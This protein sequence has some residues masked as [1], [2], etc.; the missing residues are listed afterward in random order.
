[1]S[2]FDIIGARK[3]G[4]SDAEIADHLAKSRGFD[5]A[6]ARKAGYSDAEILSH[7][8]GLAPAAQPPAEAPPVAP[9][10]PV[11]AAMSV[12]NPPRIEDAPQVG[13]GPRTSQTVTPAKPWGEVGREAWDNAPASLGNVLKATVQPILH[14]IDTANA[15][16]SVVR[17]LE[18]PRQMV[19][20]TLPNGQTVFQPQ[21]VQETA[22]ETEARTAPA[23]A[24]GDFYANRYGSVEGFKNAFA[25]DPASVFADMSVPLTAGGSVA[26]RAPGVVGKVG[27]IATTAGRVIDPVS[28]SINLTGQV[29]G[30]VGKAGEAVASNT[31][32]I[33]TGA[34]TESIR[35]AGRAGRE[36]GEAGKAFTEN[37]RG[38]VPIEN[39]VNLAKSGLDKIRKERG[40]EYRSGM[41]DISKDRTV[42]DFNDINGAINKAGEVGTFKGANIAPAA[43]DINA[44]LRTVVKDWETLNPQSPLFKDV[45]PGELTAAN[46]HTPEGLDAL[47]RTIGDLRDSTDYGSPSRI[48]A[49]RVYN[50]VKAEIISQAPAYGKIMEKYETASDKLREVGKTFSLSEK[51]TGD[52]AARKLQSATRDGAQTS[53]RKRGELLNELAVHEPDLPYAIAGQSLNAFA[54]RG[55]VGRGGA[56]Y[57][58]GSA[59]AA[60]LANPLS[61]IPSAA[62]LLAFSPRFVG[63]SVYYGGRLIGTVDKVAKSMGIDA[64]T[65]RAMGQGSFQAGRASE[66]NALARP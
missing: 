37:M 53:W 15:L 11:G 14:P 6:G 25:S 58:V 41:V 10:R 16:G 22:Q 33:T 60:L 43:N 55:L 47:K 44:Q 30:Y 40:A 57:T 62:S 64:A 38:N 35:A 45:A 5:T 1:M 52:T 20:V 23:N 18:K 24:V 34:G 8:S 12:N 31:L 19:K 56:M 17:G 65:L 32:G 3:A 61:A 48:A 4:Y 59:G 46:F 63:N 9:P 50:A 42:L 2:D 7:L 13:P 51:A 39:I 27:E 54:P 66:T 26:S 28:Q 21:D 29:G 49:D 36:G